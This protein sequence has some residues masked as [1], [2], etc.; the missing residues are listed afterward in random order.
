VLLAIAA[1]VAYMRW[2]ILP[3]RSRSEA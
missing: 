3:I 2:R 1:F